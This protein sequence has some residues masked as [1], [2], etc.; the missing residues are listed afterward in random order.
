[1]TL[2]ASGAISMADVN[3]ELG[4]AAGTAIS[5]NDADVRTLFGAGGSGTAISLDDGHGKSAYVY[6]EEGPYYQVDAPYYYWQHYSI[7]NVVTIWWDGALVFD[8]Y[9]FADSSVTIGSWVYERG[10]YQG[11]PGAYTTH[12]AI[13]R[14][15]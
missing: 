3:T 11:T 9:D 13:W 15:N 12:Y 8:E 2:P 14:H 5:L 4:H 6:T 7:S 10:V 1:M